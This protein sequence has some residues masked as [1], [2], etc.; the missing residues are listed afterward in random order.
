MVAGL[1]TAPGRQTADTDGIEAG[2]H[3]LGVLPAVDV[4][5]EPTELGIKRCWRRIENPPDHADRVVAFCDDDGEIRHRGRT[6]ILDMYVGQ[7]G[8]IQEIIVEQLVVARNMK[9]GI[10]LHHRPVRIVHHTP[11]RQQIF[12]R[13]LG[14]THPDPDVLVFLQHRP[15]SDPAVRRYFGLPRHLYTSTCPIEC[16]T[17]IAAFECIADDPAF[18]QRQVAMATPIF[19]RNNLAS[20]IAKQRQRLVEDRP[21]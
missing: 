10:P 8:Q 14:I 13:L 11:V 9:R 5:R 4:V 19:Q 12:I 17:M 16:Q 21:R 1:R 20:G 3:C 6:D 7:M 2:Y 18:G 15:G